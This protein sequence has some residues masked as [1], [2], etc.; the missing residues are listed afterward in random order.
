ME[1]REKMG[2]SLWTSSLCC[3]FL[4]VFGLVSLETSLAADAACTMWCQAAA[5]WRER[6]V[7]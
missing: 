6:S 3:S 4:D 1:I 5:G 2:R 7:D